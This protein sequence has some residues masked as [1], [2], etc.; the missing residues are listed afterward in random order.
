MRD[1]WGGQRITVFPELDMVV[2]LTGGN[3]ATHAPVN[4]IVTNY[5]LPAVR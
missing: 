3:Y 1:G 2:V 5:I 4:E